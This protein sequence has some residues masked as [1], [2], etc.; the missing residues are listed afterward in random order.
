MR[1]VSSCT[2]QF[3]LNTKMISHSTGQTETFSRG[4]SH[5]GVPYV[6]VSTNQFTYDVGGAMKTLR[7]GKL[8]LTTWAYNQYG[9]LT[10]KVEDTGQTVFRYTYDAGGRLQTRWTPEKGTT[11]YHHDPVGNLTNIDYPNSAD[12][13]LHYDAL[14]RLT[15]LVDA[16]GTT[17]YGWTAS[18]QLLSEDGPW[19]DDTVS[20]TY[21]HRL[22][23][24]LNAAQPNAAAWAQTYAYDAMKRLTNLTSAAGAFGYAYDVGQSVSPA[25]LIRALTLPGG[26]A[27]TNA[28][29]DVGRLTETILRNAA[30][31][32]LNLHTYQYDL[33]GQRTQQTRADGSYVDYGYDKMGQLV[34]AQGKESGGASRWHEQFGYAYDPAG[35]LNWRTNNDL[36]QQ[37]QVNTLNELTNVSRPGSVMT[38]AGTTTSG[39]TNVTVNGL[40]AL[41]YGDHTFARTNV[42]LSDGS[43]SFTAIALDSLGRTDTNTVSAWLP[44]AAPMQYDLNGNLTNDSRRV[45]LYDDENQLTAV[46][47]TNATGLVTRSE[48]VY[49]GKLRRRIRKEYHLTAGAWS[50]TLEVRYV[51]DGMLVVQERHFHPQL[52]TNSPQHTVTYT[53]GRDLSGTL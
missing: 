8:Q 24:G 50:Q 49:D 34:T 32:Q 27:N 9:L 47:A 31:S 3:L 29:D 35:N 15:N 19:P 20:V 11:T 36:K 16:V 10:N 23:T 25:Y 30:G 12:L 26:A 52:S 7:D 2:S 46:V 6:A 1:F 21:L 40:T 53:R 44:V 13:T 14:S 39:A 5:R 17:R 41:L 28:Y 48:F 18:G 42:G 43:N 45:L 22:R 37:F 4:I 33:A 51:C 38:V